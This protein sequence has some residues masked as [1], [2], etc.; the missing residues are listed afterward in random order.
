MTAL[1]RCIKIS[2]PEIAAMFSGCDV[3]LIPIKIE[4]QDSEHEEREWVIVPQYDLAYVGDDWA[5]WL[6]SSRFAPNLKRRN[7]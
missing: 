3:W 7:K 2:K 5:I 4:N 1:K 6:I